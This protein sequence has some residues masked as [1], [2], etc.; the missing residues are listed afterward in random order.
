MNP[1]TE[2][3]LD[4]PMDGDPGDEDVVDVSSVEQF[5]RIWWL[6]IGQNMEPE[7]D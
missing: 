1:R 4:I 3:Y 2:H 5:E 7:P 6:A